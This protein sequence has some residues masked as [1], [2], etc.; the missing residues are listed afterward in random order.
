MIPLRIIQ[1]ALIII[2]I[3]YA[4]IVFLPNQS[5]SGQVLGE[6]DIQNQ[7]SNSSGVIDQY[8]ILSTKSSFTQKELVEETILPFTEKVVM[9]DELYIGE[10]RVSQEG[11]NGKIT[12][13]YQVSY[14]QDEVVTRDLIKSEQ[15]DPV[16]KIL[17]KGTKK[18][19][20]TVSTP[21]GQITYYDVLKMRSTSYDDE[22]KGC[23]G[24]TYLGTEVTKGVCAVDPKV[25]PL[26]SRL[27]IEGYGFCRAEDIGG[28]IKGNKIDLGFDDAEEAHWGTRMVTVYMLE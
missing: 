23:T 22:C 5:R 10:S 25:I 12:E 3:S 26:R 11:V 18:N 1:T 7:V 16:E 20:R 17:E 6:R 9:T 8:Q 19:I 28:A 14:W 27:Y 21:D 15:T 2:F 4:V 24:R 13:T